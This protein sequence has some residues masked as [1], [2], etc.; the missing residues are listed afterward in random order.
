[1]PHK[2]VAVVIAMRRE[3]DPLLAGVRGQMV[4]GV[5]FFELENAVVVVGGIGRNAARRAAEVV[6]ERYQPA[7]LISAGIAGALNATLK[8]GDVLHGSE[9]VDAGSGARFRMA[10]DESVIVTVS[11][12]SGPEEKRLLADRYKADVVDMESAAVADVARERSID[13]KAIKAISDELE[14]DMPPVAGFVDG[15]GRFKT[16]RFGAYIAMRPKWWS[17]VRDLNANSRIASVNLSHAV[18]HLIEGCAINTQEE[19]VPRA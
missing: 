6:A 2:S 12:V 1:M 18:E 19:K 10:G 17:T 16:A 4:D 9:V 14:F 3:L 8:V 15:N 13:C 5:E 11:S 7:V